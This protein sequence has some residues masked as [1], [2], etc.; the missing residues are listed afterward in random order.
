MGAPKY[1]RFVVGF[2]EWVPRGL[3]L[4][5]EVRRCPLFRGSFG[6]EGPG[7]VGRGGV[8]LC[9]SAG[10][11]GGRGGIAVSAG[12][13]GGHDRGAACGDL[14]SGGWLTWTIWAAGVTALGGVTV[15]GAAAGKT[16]SGRAVA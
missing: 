4:V 9:A 3:Y 7:E 14:G 2:E 11:V 10:P 1:A 5:D 16:V 15:E 6:G 13:A 12:G 8:R